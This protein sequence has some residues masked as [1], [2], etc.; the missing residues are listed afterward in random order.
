MTRVGESFR[1]GFGSCNRQTHDMSLWEDVANEAYDAFAWIGDAV[2]ADARTGRMPNGKKGRVYLGEKAHAEAF[3]FVK[4][5]PA[6]ARVRATAHVTGTWDDH[7]YGFNN[8]G[9][10]WPHKEFAR[11]AFLDFLDE[12]PASERRKREGGVY[13]SVDYVHA[14]RR[15]RLILLD[16]RWDLEEADESSEGRMMSEQQWEWLDEQL[17]AEPKPAFTILASGIQVLEAP[18]LMLRPLAPYVQPARLVAEGLESWSR[19]HR[20][21]TRLF[22]AIKRA[23]A[24]VIFISGDV[25]HGQIAVSAPG[26]HLPYKTIDV[27]SSGFTHTPFR[28]AKPRVLAALLVWATPKYFGSWILP[29]FTRWTD[30]NYG[31]IEVDWKRGVIFTRVKSTGGKTVLQET[32]PFR[33]FELNV[34]DLGFDRTG[35]NETLELSPNM[36]AVRI[37]LFFAWLACVYALKLLIPVCVLAWLTRKL[38]RRTRV[39]AD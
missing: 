10:H 13:D 5:H 39:K 38:S 18:Y 36:R 7:D 17:A 29:S 9:K 22:D 20:D 28:E 23:N 25:H 24:K 8:A 14:G 26:C 35:C 21:Q 16:L 31:E 11:N 4:R 32:M 19:M 30:I 15:L 3:E 12:P 2:Y 34:P 33:E 37:V 6:Y 1:L 27:T